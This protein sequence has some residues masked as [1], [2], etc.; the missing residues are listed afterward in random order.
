MNRCR[1]CIALTVAVVAGL[2]SAATVVRAAPVNDSDKIPNFSSDDVKLTLEPSPLKLAD[3]PEAKW[4]QRSGDNWFYQ[5]Y[6]TLWAASIN[7]TVG[8]NETQTDI[9]VSFDDILDKTDVA[10]GL[11]FEAGKGPWSVIF[12][13]QYMKLKSDGTTR[14]GN[15]ADVEADFLLIDA[16][17]SYQLWETSFGDHEKL[18]IDGLVGI[19]W[20]YLKLQ[21]DINQGPLAGFSR[22]RD[23]DWVDPY[24]G[25]RARWYISREWEVEASATIGGF[26][27][28]SDTAWSALV[29][30][31]YRFSQKFS[32]VLGYRAFGWDYDDQIIWDV[33]MH[34]PV[35]GISFR[36]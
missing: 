2:F 15:D 1:W 32:A 11:N 35:L 29:L 17:F 6:M 20:T 28:G 26:G 34:G 27:V 8:K 5:S 19:R 13:G 14:N 10:F 33:T 30:G 4:D 7:G 23:V 12:F 22:D 3:Q 21:V 18:A 9:D 24:V 16:A 31:E 36:W 25:A